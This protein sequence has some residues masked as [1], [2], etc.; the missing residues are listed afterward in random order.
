MDNSAFVAPDAQ[1]LD[2]TEHFLVSQ[3]GS[4]RRTTVSQLSG[5]NTQSGTS[6]TLQSTDN[7]KIV[8]CTSA[9]AVT[10]TVPSGLGAGFECGILQRGAGQ[11]TTSPSGGVT[12]S[13]RQSFTKTAGQY[14][15]ISLIAPVADTFILT[16]DGA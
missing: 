2:G 11:V 10:V 6:Y 9:S 5:F 1:T 16:G 3:S 7:G 4:V 13:N 15:L 12:V 8:D 14:G